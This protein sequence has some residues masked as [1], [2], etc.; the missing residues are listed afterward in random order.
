MTWANVDMDVDESQHAVCVN[1]WMARASNGLSP[2]ELLR[3]FEDGFAALWRRAQ[4]TLGDVTLVAIGD[5][6]L[7][8]M[9]ERSPAFS[10]LKLEATG[11]RLDEFRERA[12]GLPNAELADG[13]R[14]FLVE[15][16]TVLGNLTAEV[17]TPALHSE[18][19]K[20]APAQSDAGA[21]QK[22]GQHCTQEYEGEDSKP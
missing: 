14:G 20:L 5:R 17:L 12:K 15:F 10:A 11:L 19:S 9:A 21:R 7:H 2:A 8:T 1:A 18:L 4:K 13:I 3:A 6:V 22:N 16:L